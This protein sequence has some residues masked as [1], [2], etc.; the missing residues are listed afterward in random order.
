MA[1]PVVTGALA[2]VHQM[3]PHM[4]GENLVKLLTVTADKD[5]PGYAVHTHGQGMLDLDK[6]TQ[7]VGA[8]GIPT[9]GRTSGQISNI[10]TLS[11]GAGIGSVNS[12]AFAALS[13]VVVLDSFE[14]D[15]TIDLSQT[16]AIDT[17]PGSQVE[18]ISFGNT[19]DGY[20]NLAN[21]GQFSTDVLGIRTSFK[22]DP[23]Q[24][25]NGDLGM[26]TEY[27]A[28]KTEDT[29]LT[30]ALGM[31]K[32][33][34]KFLNNVQQGFMGVGENHTTNY[35]GVSLN[36]KFDDNW[37]GFGNY[38]MGITDVESSKEFSL[39]T[40][41]SNL[42]SN[43]WGA[44]AGYK[45]KNGLSMGASVSQPLAITSGKMNYKV[46]VGRTLDGQVLFDEGSADASTKHIEVDTGVFI[47]YNV[48]NVAVA[49]YAEHRRNVAGVNDN[50]EVNLG[51]KVNY[52]F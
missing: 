20:W 51:I 18:A 32:E 27:D 15:F 37:F 38:Q 40:G 19:Y 13:N 29:I 52:K 2:V 4:K 17:R 1:A 39:V 41:Y 25:G 35:V 21:S 42:V 46:P 50:N 16:Q 44:G 47:K 5:L 49:G 14:R 34:G 24:R 10:A 23:K 22:M 28:Y 36:H 8:T 48:D 33:T 9:S 11:G 12:E 43:T 31:V 30:A 7:P 26:R 45:F 6:A 3:W